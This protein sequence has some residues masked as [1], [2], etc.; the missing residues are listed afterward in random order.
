[1]P[2]DNPMQTIIVERVIAAPPEAVFDL[3]TDSNSLRFTAL[4]LSV[5]RVAEGRDGGWSAGAVREV[6]GAG[7]WFREEVTANDRPHKFGYQILKAVP[8]LNHF[9]GTIEVT[10]TAGGSRVVW[11]S[12]Y[13]VPVAAGGKVTAAVF[14]RILTMSFGQILA[15][16]DKKLTSTGH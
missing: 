14:R 8:P 11:Q 9:G 7:A 3:V 12:S 1:M 10:P 13:D 15:K 5:K 4:V 6:I 16:A 2:I